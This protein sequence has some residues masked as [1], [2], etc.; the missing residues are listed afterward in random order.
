[1]AERTCSIEGCGRKH[2]ARG[3]CSTHYERWRRT[4][5]P[6][7]DRP[8]MLMLRDRECT[9]EG[10]EAPHEGLGYCRKH[11]RRLVYHGDVELLIGPTH[12][13]WRGEDITYS[14]AHRRVERRRGAASA[15]SCV[16]CG[17]RAAHWALRHEASARLLDSDGRSFSAD[18]GDYQPMCVVCHAAY[19]RKLA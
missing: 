11:Y 1:M 16:R 15:L 13:H 9:V 19:D 3:W 2:M 12:P 17:G 6:Q 8:V 5:S 10:C 18:P 14:G 4:G 7:D